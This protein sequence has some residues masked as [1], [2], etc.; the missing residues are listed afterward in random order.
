[1]TQLGL[2]PRWSVPVWLNHHC[3][4]L[5]N[6]TPLRP[7]PAKNVDIQIP[8]AWASGTYTVKGPFGCDPVKG[9]EAGR[10]S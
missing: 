6:A 8:A 5:S 10:L 2:E 1:M 7:L 4:R 9:A 3:D